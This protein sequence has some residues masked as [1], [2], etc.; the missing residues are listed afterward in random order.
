MSE[1]KYTWHKVAD[2][3]NELA[4]GDNNLAVV[5]LDGKKICIARFNDQLFAV[6][7]KCPHAGGLLA[8]GYIDALGQVV[9]PLHRYKFSLASGRNTS[10]E[11]Y[12][13]RRWP[14]ELR[15][16]GVFVGKEKAGGLFGNIF[17]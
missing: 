15:E 7:Y 3:L 10:G 1:R 2:H 6:G 17:R 4:F 13:L 14:V 5:E 16:D 8:E 12:Y 11:G 9:C